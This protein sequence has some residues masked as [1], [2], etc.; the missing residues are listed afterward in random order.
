MLCF[1]GVVES[2]FELG[3]WRYIG[4]WGL[5]LESCMVGIWRVQGRG[6]ELI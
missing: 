1:F 2:G 4:V 6:V 5:D 3:L